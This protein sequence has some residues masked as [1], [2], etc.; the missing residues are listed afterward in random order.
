MIGR[1]DATGFT[2]KVSF[3]GNRSGGS[4]RGLIDVSGHEHQS[5]LDVGSH[6]GL[7]DRFGVPVQLQTDMEQAF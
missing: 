5:L 6:L 7:L 4:L 3:D 2:F 1:R